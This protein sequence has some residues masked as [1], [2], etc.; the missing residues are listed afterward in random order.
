[1][2]AALRLL[3]TCFCLCS[4]KGGHLHVR[5]CNLTKHTVPLAYRL[6]VP[7]SQANLKH[8]NEVLQVVLEYSVGTRLLRQ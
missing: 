3:W 5:V 7:D 2:R 8:R 6:G 1:L 4:T